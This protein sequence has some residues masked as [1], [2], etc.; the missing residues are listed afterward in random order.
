MKMQRIVNIAVILL[1]VVIVGFA[2]LAF[3]PVEERPDWVDDLGYRD[4]RLFSL[5]VDGNGLPLISV[6]VTGFNTEMVFDTGNHVG[7]KIHED[8]VQRLG[9]IPVDTTTERDIE[10]NIIRDINV[11]NLGEVYIFR[12]FYR[13]VRAHETRVLGIEGSVGPFF[14]A[15][16][17]VTL[18]YSNSLIG[19]TD[20]PLP[21]AYSDQALPII[22]GD[23]PILTIIQGRVQG[24][25]TLIQLDTGQPQTIIDT[26]LASSLDLDTE[27]KSTAVQ[28]IRVGGKEFNVESAEI[29]SIKTPDQ[30]LQQDVQLILGSDVL[31][32]V[33]LTIDYNRGV[34]LLL[35]G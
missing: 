1:V 22:Q 20:S 33:L 21:E 35:D 25:E 7:L 27:N 34:V 32:Q 13:N 6:F 8:L 19:V 24:E 17:R 11:Y 3:E 9:V 12:S 23:N 29:L 16:R 14:V 31:S 5:S 15:D 10:G 30:G 2:V 18:D 28:G 4:Y 26:Q